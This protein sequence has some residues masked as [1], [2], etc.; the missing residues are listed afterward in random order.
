L[1]PAADYKKALAGGP[2]FIE[3]ADSYPNLLRRA[4]WALTDHV[5]LTAQ[6]LASTRRVL[7]QEQARA[8]DLDHLL[9]ANETSQVRDRR[10]ATINALEQGLLR[11][12]LFHTVPLRAGE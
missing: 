8:D 2:T 4:G 3:S 1:K 7:E 11:R 12:E 10:H 9:G 6:Y 5:D